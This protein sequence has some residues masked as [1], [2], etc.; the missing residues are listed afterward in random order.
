MA[1]SKKYKR[2]FKRTAAAA[3][4]VML[5][6]LSL[7]MGQAAAADAGQNELK[8][9]ETD[10]QMPGSE[11]AKGIWEQWK[12]TAAETP[13]SGELV[14]AGP[15]E[16]RWNALS[17]LPWNTVSYR[18]YLDGEF[19]EEIQAEE[20][21]S[22]LSCNIYTTETASHQLK[23]EAVL[24][25]EKKVTANIRTFFVSKKGLGIPT[26]S[27]VMAQD[28]N[29]SWYYNWSSAPDVRVKDNL[30]FVPMIWGDYEQGKAWLAD[31]TNQIYGTVLGY[32]EPDRADQSNLSVQTAAEN[33][34]LF[35]DSGLRVGAPAV[36][37]PPSWN[38]LWFQEYSE[39]I[40][41]DDVDFIP[42]HCYLDWADG[43]A[44]RL[45][46]AIDE[47][48][49]RYQKPIWITEFAIARWDE[50][51]PCFNGQ[52]AQK[53]QE[54]C[55]YMQE[56]LAGLEA[57]DYVERYAWQQFDMNDWA[58]GSSALYNEKTGELTAL[59]TLYRNLGNPEGYV[60]PELDGTAN[61]QTVS[62][63]YVDEQWDALS[64]GGQNSN[65]NLPEENENSSGSDNGITGGSQP[66]DSGGSRT[67]TSAVNPVKQSAPK[68]GDHAMWMLSAAGMLL[69]A[70][71]LNAYRKKRVN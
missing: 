32:N 11:A 52:D 67:P 2:Y 57:R 36:S 14:P 63:A 38:N 64:D 33:Q 60:L 22:L 62:D 6:C 65:D 26:E 15:I 13:V 20:G 3:F 39:S 8:A 49:E 37:Y 35:T 54:V 31:E 30:T 58:G 45:L 5:C 34:Q 4:S 40:D 19:Q 42:L 43:N 25:N 56:V 28:M 16:V 9:G 50:N 44:D 41:M 17:G 21:E 53:N 59:G 46:E 68:T 23:I 71:A 47:T 1:D 51:Y 18:I 61:Q 7:S 24:E 55:Q 69:S 48:Y 29:G 66:P 10:N 70:A 27:P 12:T